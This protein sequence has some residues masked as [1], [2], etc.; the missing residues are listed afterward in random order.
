MSFL[1]VNLISG[2]KY[3][4]KPFTPVMNNSEFISSMPNMV[5]I[6]LVYSN[7]KGFLKLQ[8]L[9][10]VIVIGSLGYASNVVVGY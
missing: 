10:I 9:L 1:F 5:M 8:D 6:T 7:L 4:D 3:S 2:F